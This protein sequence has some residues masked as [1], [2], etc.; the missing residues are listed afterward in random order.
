MKRVKLKQNGKS[1]KFC[2][3]DSYFDK[4]I[5][6]IKTSFNVEIVWLMISLNISL[7]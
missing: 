5:D 2:E 4:S 1:I 7:V 3:K 6:Y